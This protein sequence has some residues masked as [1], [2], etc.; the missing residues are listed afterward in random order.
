MPH[1]DKTLANMLKVA[2]PVSLP[3]IE[4]PPAIIVRDTPREKIE[5]RIRSNAEKMGVELGEEHWE[6]IRF[7]FD[8]Y[9]HCCNTDDPGYISQ[10]VY[11]KYVDCLYDDDCRNEMAGEDDGDCPYGQLSRTEASKAYPVYRILAKAFKDKGGS[12]H[13]YTLFPYGPLYTI[14][15]LAQLPRLRNDANPHF[16]TAF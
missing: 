5:S 15:L 14:H 10:E 4:Y 9:E 7:L 8:F 11:W 3:P 13:L 16:G 2:Q 12:K 1:D 6:V